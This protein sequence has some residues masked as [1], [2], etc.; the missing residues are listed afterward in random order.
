MIFRHDENAFRLKALWKW[1]MYI[2]D[3][4]LFHLS[5]SNG[6]T[7]LNKEENSYFS[8]WM[9]R[10]KHLF[11]GEDAHSSKESNEYES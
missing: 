2:I 7:P 10:V 11:R 3:I 1:Y 4:C 5:I 9:V 8:Y 6:D